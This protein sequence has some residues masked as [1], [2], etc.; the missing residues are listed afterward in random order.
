MRKDLR[1]RLAGG[2]FAAVLPERSRAMRAVKSR[3]NRSTELRL[4]MALVRGGLRGWTL[5]PPEIEGRPD[6][7]FPSKR[8]VV[9]VDGC[10]W[11]GC[12]VCGHVPATNSAFW[13]AKLRHRRQRDRQVTKA[14]RQQGYVLI[15]FW[16]HTLRGGLEPCVDRIRDTYYSM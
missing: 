5:H 7:F 15:R 2:R 12:P 13:A 3:G 10:F 8:L 6:F 16:E 11:H 4:R 1:E 9:F 14:L